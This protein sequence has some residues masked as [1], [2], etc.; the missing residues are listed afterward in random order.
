MAR[1]RKPVSILKL[2]GTAQRCRTE[3]RKHELALS[4]DIP[5]PPE[6]L[7]GKGLDE[8][9]RLLQIADYRPVIKGADQTALAAY[10]KLAA[11]LANGEDFKSTEWQAFIT[12]TGRFGLTPADRCK[13][14]VEAPTRQENPFAKF[15]TGT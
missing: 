3:P 2:Q 1:P 10:C 12:L 8:W 4:G 9:H 6:W 11:K 5:T 7:T 14:K 15:Q 13:I